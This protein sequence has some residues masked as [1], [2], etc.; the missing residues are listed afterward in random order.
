MGYLQPIPM[1]LFPK[2]KVLH[3]LYFIISAQNFAYYFLR[4]II[5]NFWYF[6]WVVKLMIPE[7]FTLFLLV[8]FFS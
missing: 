5:M 4:K 6:T 2:N 3:N 1:T 8:K 7:S